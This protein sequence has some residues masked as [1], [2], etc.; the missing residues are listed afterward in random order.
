MYFNYENSQ[1]D[2]FLPIRIIIWLMKNEEM[3]ILFN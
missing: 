3:I 2:V 1:T